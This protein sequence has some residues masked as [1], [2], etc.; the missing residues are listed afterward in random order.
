MKSLWWRLAIVG[1]V[2][3]AWIN[4]FFPVK[5]RDFLATFASLAA[6]QLAERRGQ[7]TAEARQALA[8][9]DRLL[10]RTRELLAQPP[11]GEDGKPRPLAPSLA[12]K[13][14]AKGLEE[15]RRIQLRDF[16]AVPGNPKASNDLVISFVRKKSQGKFRLGLDLRGGTE[17]IIG[18]DPGKVPEGR[19]V[20]DVR[21]N[22][23]EIL[24]NRVDAMGVAE[25]EIKPVGPNSI[26]LRMPS[27]TE[28]EKE[29][30][31]RT[32][33]QTAKL[34][35]HLVHP[36]NDAQLMQFRQNPRTYLPPP[37]YEVREM[38][39][40]HNGEQRIEHL[41]V[42]TRDEPVKG[43][44]LDRAVPTFNEFGNYSVSLRF[45]AA[46]AKAFG[47][48]T[49][50]NV[51][52]R[53]A[54][55][56]DGRIYSAPR[57]NEPIWGGGAEISGSFSPEEAQQLA[58]VL[59]CG[60]LPVSISID[61]EF[62]TDPT[63]GAESIRAGVLACVAG[64]L[65]V[66]LFMLFYYRLSGIVAVTALAANLVL[67]V[68]TMTL[69][70][71]TFTLPGLAGIALTV[72][73]A[74]DANILI[75]ERIREELA[76]GKS[77]ENAVRTGFSRAFLTIF[78]S[79]ITTLFTGLIL[80]RFG[81]GSVRGFAVTL[82]IGLVANLFTAVFFSRALFE[83]MLTR[84]GLKKL[85]MLQL[86]RHPNIDILRHRKWTFA[87]SGLLI[88]LALG[89]MAVRGRNALGTDFTGGTVITYSY[90][91][92][93]GAAKPAE[94]EVR[95]AIEATGQKVVRI[96]SKYAGMA[97]EHQL[98]IVLPVVAAAEGETQTPLAAIG[99]ALEKQFPQ[100]AFKQLQTYRVGGLVGAQFQKRAIL[101]ILLSWLSI[102]LYVSF[103]FEFAYG[104]AS[105][106]ALVHD[107]IIGV[108]LYLLCGREISL[109]VLAGILTIIGY[110]INDTI[111]VFDR[112]R[113]GFAL[114]RG[115]TY[116]EVVKASI[117]ETLSRT[118]L[119]S[120]TTLF[121]VLALFFLGGGALNDLALLMFFGMIT[122]TYSSIFIASA[123]IVSWHKRL[124]AHVVAAE[125]E[126]EPA[127]TA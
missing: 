86:F 72:G 37:G 122:G 20:V 16:V 59:Q 91:L 21:D 113:E 114:K 49:A 61:S 46:G 65:V 123:I 93:A 108:G 32:I 64:A 41:L 6:P 31:R 47:Q 92:P 39:V 75:F 44:Q 35:F 97:E 96:G 83:L 14:A 29:D 105:V 51:G 13:Q 55:V 101:A 98:E 26:S 60:R 34:G 71:A 124:P 22:I 88:L 76:N 116:G 109:T 110:S 117:N 62:G 48:V 89:A 40:E 7:D 27:V 30:I 69:L 28:N 95:K 77:L 119:T 10:A 111:V 78:D 1:L 125:P 18:F 100:Y 15:G 106:L 56:L 68:G 94:G 87:F 2:L 103:R 102:I 127:T 50:D 17:F 120:A 58:V 104:V 38:E 80:M 84:F 99:T 36:D 4:S 63:L 79:N 33:Q 67:L 107:V 53:M 74:V 66:V 57:I 8:D 25:P 112:I 24:R 5:D 126:P 121:S 52:N 118:V 73:M 19:T 3:G 12:L 115:L 85:R 45:N 70:P 90:H 82:I 54:I 9:F 42:K 81:T 43:D 23:L 11:V